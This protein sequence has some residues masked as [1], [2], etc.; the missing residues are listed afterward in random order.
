[1]TA[2]GFKTKLT[3]PSPLPGPL[4]DRLK[5]YFPPRR[6]DYI[7]RVLTAG[8][9]SVIADLADALIIARIKRMPARRLR[10]L[11]ALEPACAE[12][13]RL[14]GRLQ[15]HWLHAEEYLLATRL[16]R[17][18]S[19]RELFADFMR[20]ENGPRFRAYFALKFPDRVR[21]VRRCEPSA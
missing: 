15:L 7:A 5:A 9:L 13:R 4:R 2:T 18:P 12:D 6:I 16:G 20:N 19:H 10:R 11:D 1:M 3:A 8:E 14:F 21:R 17:R